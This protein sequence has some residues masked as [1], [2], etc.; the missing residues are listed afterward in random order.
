MRGRKFTVVPGNDGPRRRRFPEGTLVLPPVSLHELPPD[1]I[2]G[3]FLGIPALKFT[4]ATG[5]VAV[6]LHDLRRA[7]IDA[8]L[9]QQRAVAESHL[10]L[11]Y[12]RRRQWWEGR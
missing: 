3:R 9:A 11:N 6:F 4:T 5:L 7:D 2:V 8:L 1:G 12:A 10:G